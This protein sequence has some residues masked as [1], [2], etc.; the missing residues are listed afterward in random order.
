MPSLSHEKPSI[1]CL[2]QQSIDRLWFILGLRG[3]LFF[4]ELAA[5]FWSRSLSLLAGAGHLFSDLI[6]LGLTLWVIRLLRQK[7]Q[8][9]TKRYERLEAWIALLNGFSLVGIAIV[10]TREALNYLQHPEPIWG[11]PMLGA[12]ILSLVINTYCS[13]LLYKDSL[14]SLSVRGIFLHG[15]ADFSS[16]IG[17]LLSALAVYC[18]GWVW[19]DAIVSLLV[20]LLIYLTAF[21]LV[22]DSLAI[23][24]SH[25]KA[26]DRA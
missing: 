25:W 14:H 10:I 8:E 19:T 9:L 17:V 13:Y 3:G 22:R 24:I 26:V 2:D 6:A 21:A 12:A 1:A 5:G 16:S 4:V 11:V 7:Q 23:F 15:V 18:F 20:A